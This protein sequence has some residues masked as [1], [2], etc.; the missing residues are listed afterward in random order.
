MHQK[1]ERE[2]HISKPIENLNENKEQ[3][4]TG[5]SHKNDK[6]WI[7]NIV[8]KVQNCFSYFKDIISDKTE[9]IIGNNH[10]NKMTSTGLINE[11][12]LIPELILE[13][14]DTQCDEIDKEVVTLFFKSELTASSTN[15]V[16]F[17]ENSPCNYT[18]CSIR[19]PY[20]QNFQV[21]LSTCLP[22]SLS[23]S[24]FTMKNTRNTVP[25][26]KYRTLLDE[27]FFCLKDIAKSILLLTTVLKKVHKNE[28]PS[29]YSSAK[30]FSSIYKI[31]KIFQS[32]TSIN[33][34]VY[35]EN[36][37]ALDNNQDVKS[38]FQP[39]KVQSIIK[40]L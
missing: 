21:Y 33:K 11:I 34:E 9:E 24:N 2:I 14:Q 6:N 4:S 20:C 19:N 22:Q 7:P 12:D 37:R 36:L 31:E 25:L 38:Y 1:Q 8:K 10:C 17:I 16:P 5:S 27:Q 32:V 26:L 35:E 28:Q 18:E 15:Y 40:L 13:N 3:K 23:E 30:Y 29:V 39:L